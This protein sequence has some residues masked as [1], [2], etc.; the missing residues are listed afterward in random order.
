MLFRSRCAPRRPLFYGEAPGLAQPRALRL[1]FIRTRS[2][3]K[4]AKTN[5]FGFLI[6]AGEIVLRPRSGLSCLHRFRPLRRTSASVSACSNGSLRVTAPMVR[7]GLCRL[8]PHSWR[9]RAPIVEAAPQQALPLE[10]TVDARIRAPA[11]RPGQNQ[12]RSVGGQIN[13][14]RSQEDS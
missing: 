5:G 8:L 11:K 4:V 2:N 10:Q 13:Y 1:L 9:W 6:I 14:P 7:R 12:P 3:Q